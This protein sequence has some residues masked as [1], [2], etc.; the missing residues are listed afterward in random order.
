MSL[1]LT[2]RP[3]ASDR[4]DRIAQ[5]ARIELAML[6]RNGEQLLLAFVIPVGLLVGGMLFGD[7][8]GLDRT[9]FP[10]SVMALAVWSSS[11][12]SLAINTAFER[13][14]GVLE[15]LAATPLTRGDLIAGKAQAT[16]TITAVQVLALTLLALALGWRPNPPPMVS[17]VTWPLVVLA[18]FAFAC[19]G[20][21]LAGRLEATVVL[22]LAN[23]VYL[24]GAAG[25]GLVVPLSSYPDAVRAVLALLPTAALGEALRGWAS[26]E[27]TWW[28]YPVLGAWCL[29]LLFVARKAFRW[30]S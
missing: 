17:L 9:T 3:G 20:L 10:A 21:V 8:F 25:G 11:F 19:L 18:A 22:G 16:I 2:P 23:L 12:T 27:F 28:A 30:T 6:L 13:R 29:V 7:R 5:H 24:V 26:G 1:D 4:R 15:R 14:Y